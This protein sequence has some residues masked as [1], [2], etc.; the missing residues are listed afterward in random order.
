MT[1]AP[2]S[3]HPGWFFPSAPFS[4]DK[5]HPKQGF[6]LVKLLM[7]LALFSLLLFAFP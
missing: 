1:Y 3:L 5:E 4:N 7:Q 6:L 2:S